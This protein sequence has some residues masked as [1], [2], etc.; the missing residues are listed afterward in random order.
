MTNRESD[1]GARAIVARPALREN[2]RFAA[3]RFVLAG[4]GAV[5][6]AGWEDG[7]RL[8]AASKGVSYPQI[9]QPVDASLP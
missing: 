7:Q 4:F 3:W 8:Y 6:L 5:A 2:W 1:L 9:G